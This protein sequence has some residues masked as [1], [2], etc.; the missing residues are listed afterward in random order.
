MKIQEF[1]D[2]LEK[3]QLVSSRIIKQVREKVAKGDRKITS[4][5][6]LKYLVKKE[7]ITR[8]QAKS[9]LETSLTV[10]AAA[11]SSILGMQ[12]LTPEK[13]L[14]KPKPKE[15]PKEDS[16]EIPTLQPVDAVP[17]TTEPPTIE[18]SVEE[19][20][21]LS[22]MTQTTLV[23]ETLDEEDEPDGPGRKKKKKSR[24][25]KGNE[26][27]TPLLLFGGGG[28]IVLILAGVIIGYLLSREDAD[29]ILA[30]ASEY[31]DGGSWTQAI[32]QY[33]R[34]L[35]GNK[36]HPDYSRA[37]VKLGLA[38]IWKATAQ[39]GNFSSAL[40][41][42]QEVLD[43]IEDEKEFEIAKRDLSSLLPSIA[44]GLAEDAE[45]AEAGEQVEQY[46]AESKEALSLCNN[47]K[48][49]PS[50][51]RDD[52][53]INGILETLDRVEREQEQRSQ[54]KGALEK[55]QAA[56]DSGDTPEAYAVH[57]QLLKDYPGLLNNETLAAKVE[58]ISAAEQAGVKFSE[59]SKEA[60]TSEL[61]S[62][63]VA[64]LA[65][66][67]RSGKESGTEGV[68]GVRVDGSMYA[69]NANNGQ[70]LWRKYLGQSAGSQI[71]TLPEGDF[72]A[73]DFTRNELVRFDASTGKLIWRQQFEGPIASPVVVESQ[74]LVT[75]KSG[76]LHLVDAATG[77]R[78]G[79]FSFGQTLPVPPA[80]NERKGKVYLLGEHSS[81]YT[82]SLE[83]M[84]CLGVFF[85][86]H[87]RGSIATS[88]VVVLDKVAVAENSG[89]ATSKLHLLAPG[90]GGAIAAND[91]TRRL[92]GLVTTPLLVDGRRLVALTSRGEVTV[93]EVSASQGKEALTKIATREAESGKQVAR[94]GLLAAGHVWSA[95]TQLNKLAVLPTGNRL[96]VEDI[97][98]DYV[99][100]T[101]DY[102][103]QAVGDIVVHLR[104]PQ[105]HAG[106]IVAAMNAE[107]GKALWQTELGVPLAGPPAVD[108]KG[109][110]IGAITSSGA[111]YLLDRQAMVDR[112]QDTAQKLRGR[113]KLPTLTSAADLGG[114]RMALGSPGTKTLVHFRP[115]APRGPLTK[116]ELPE[117]L[118]CPVV[119]WDDTFVAPTT[120]GQVY[121]YEAD[122]GNQWGSPFQPKLSVES[123]YEWLQP[124]VYGSGAESSLV[125][126]DG[127]ENIFL[128]RRATSPQANL[129]KQ[130]E[131][132]VSGSPLVTPLAVVGDMVYAGNQGN[133]LS[134]YS[135]PD[136]QPQEDIPLGGSVVWG[137]H[138]VGENMLLTTSDNQMICVGS[139]GSVVWQQALS[140]GHPTGVPLLDSGTVTLVWQQSGLSQLDLSNGTEN[141]YLDLPQPV[142][143]G[144]IAFGKR[145][146]M[147]SADGAL[148]ILDR[149]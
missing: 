109:P 136:L 8:T 3:R 124:A 17:P 61:P 81:L 7:L 91:T 39:G 59:D 127:K 134:R 84:K 54:L 73:I 138:S 147:A 123:K 105:K 38:K 37:K 4:K 85:V 49:I 140:H 101:F 106:S 77:R 36:T 83:D 120:V 133:R 110:R 108:S 20:A 129:E 62:P 74:L 5:S 145:L 116:I 57:K 111:A 149:P 69:L 103:L 148:L 46:V 34:F 100:D 135:L 66:A 137:P 107:S 82:L 117:P 95:G 102:Q 52:I 19:M 30:E 68:V 88:P 92:E 11:E 142:V 26:F 56:I 98:F 89:R 78:T 18:E 131:G 99:G 97:D 146:L 55:I 72:L 1:I 21:S 65:L 32:S 125:I 76:K 121:L 112:V 70:L 118:A 41:T 93:Y 75:E 94:F 67:V 45:G 122:T 51:Y 23:E 50:T 143:T 13:Q 43:S 2:L 132:P 48:F 96:P 35:E 27:D 22:G 42:T 6:L 60:E 144:P 80:V 53:V 40:D 44:K 14:K 128:L 115:E 114:G 64:E 25:K 86:G 141:G 104:H 71:V 28:L 79:F 16:E 31:Y 58:E 15:E 113:S 130:T 29:A 47:T 119:A 63:F 33:E 10:T 24:K 87:E 90:D 12:V 9:L 139:E 126:S